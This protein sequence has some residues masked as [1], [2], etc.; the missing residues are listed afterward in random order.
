M[1]TATAAAASTSSADRVEGNVGSPMIGSGS[2]G[3]V[4]GVVPPVA[5]DVLVVRVGVS[6]AAGALHVLA[7][8]RGRCKEAREF[9]SSVC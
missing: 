7:V 2:V 6:V 4:L 3:D 5:A 1:V 8:G 9:K